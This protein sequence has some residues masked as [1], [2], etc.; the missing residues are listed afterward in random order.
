MKCDV[1]FQPPSY[2]SDIQCFDMSIHILILRQSREIL[3]IIADEA[4]GNSPS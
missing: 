4:P 1:S 3:S 2:N